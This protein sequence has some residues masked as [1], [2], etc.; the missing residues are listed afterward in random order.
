MILFF[1]LWAALFPVAWWLTY[2]GSELL[3]PQERGE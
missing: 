3:F 1:G 2:F